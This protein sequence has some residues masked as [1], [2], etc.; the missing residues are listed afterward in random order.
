VLAPLWDRAL[1]QSGYRPGYVVIVRHPLEVAGS[2]E[3]QGD[4]AVADG[5]S[6]WLTYMRR[7]ALFVDTSGADVVHVRYTELLDDWRGVVQR[8][9]RRLDVPLALEERADEVDRFLEAGMRSHQAA[10]ADL[11]AH[12]AGAN[13]EAIGA[14]YRR[15]LQRCERDAIESAQR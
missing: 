7:V 15:L 13:G 1:K 11:E 5:L 3:T 2:L 8:I 9:A 4:M 14:L 6:L 12:V 10:D